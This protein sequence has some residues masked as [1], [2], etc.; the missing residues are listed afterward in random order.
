MYNFVNAQ[1]SSGDTLL[2]L[3]AKVADVAEIAC[4]LKQ[5]SRIHTDLL[6]ITQPW[7]RGKETTA[8]R[9]VW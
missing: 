2:V 7:E 9:I 3:I 1:S 6:E 5:T 4:N 8:W